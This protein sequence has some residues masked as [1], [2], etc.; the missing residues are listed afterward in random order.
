MTAQTSVIEIL[1]LLAGILFLIYWVLSW[2]TM[3]QS[4][5]GL[6]ML[7]QLPQYEN[8]QSGPKISIIVT[9][10]NEEKYL[11]ETIPRLL[12]QTYRTFELILI[13]DRST[14]RTGEIIESFVSQ[15]SR[16]RS[17]HIDY[18]PDNWLGKV[19]ALQKGVEIAS[20][21]YYLFTDADIEFHATA[22]SSAI[23]YVESHHVD[24][25]AVFPFNRGRKTFSMGLL[26]MAFAIL[27]FNATKIQKV[28]DPSDKSHI[29]TGAFN[30][31]KKSSFNKTPGF[32]WLRLEVIDD[33]GLGLMLKKAGFQTHVLNGFGAI[34]MNWYP[35]LWAMIQG[36][37][38]NLFPALG[39]YSYGKSLVRGLIILGTGIAPLAASVYTSSWALGTATLLFQSLIPGVSGLIVR[40][41]TKQ[42]AY[43]GFLIP[44]GYLIFVFALAQS[45][46]LHWY[47]KGINWRGTWY[48]TKKLQGESR[49]RL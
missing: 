42:N 44:L 6:K 18:L 31:V 37:E 17:I 2:F 33:S 40:Q 12:A 32:K 10:C 3:R 1:A 4:L 43:I 7:S 48:S 15:D 36:L 30:L 22:I 20:G 5:G 8:E 21:D 14:D 9:A 29:G 27:Y 41:H 34:E 38:K 26:S 28:S 47:R 19:N 49:V 35:N 45:T 25:L 16:V 13:N 24:H 46:F 23:K 39:H 11:E